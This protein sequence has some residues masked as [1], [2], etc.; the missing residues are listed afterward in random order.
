MI[1]ICSVSACYEASSLKEN[2][3][4]FIRSPLPIF[5]ILGIAAGLR[6]ANLY[7]WSLWEDEE[8]TIYFSQHLDHSFPSS[9]PIFF[10]LLNGLFRLTGISVE[11]GRLIP[12]AA[13]VLSVW[14]VYVCFKR[15]VSRETALL[16]SLFL[17]INLGHLFWSQSIRY[18][19][20]VFAFQLLSMYWFIYGFESGK[21]RFLLFSCLAFALSL[22]SHSSAILLAPVYV[23]FLAFIQPHKLDARHF[24]QIG[25]I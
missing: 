19:V 1:R 18:Y 20:L 8:T 17:A 5:V 21:Y 11:V 4:R 6:F 15:L 3:L 9:F 24:V 12:A 16:A 22:F 13:G 2:I 25:K 7:E 10:I 23:V 14:L